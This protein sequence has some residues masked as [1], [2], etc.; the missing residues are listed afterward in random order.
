MTHEQGPWTADGYLPPVSTNQ[1]RV[2]EAAPLLFA[3]LVA[4]FDEVP[5]IDRILVENGIRD[6]VV[7][8]LR[9]AT[10]HEID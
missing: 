5:D 9:A 3:A 4:V 2:R 1:A 6:I 10:G 7:N 8:A